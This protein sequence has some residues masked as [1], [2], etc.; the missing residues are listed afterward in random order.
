M[1]F[2]RR[3]DDERDGGQEHEGEQIGLPG[4][5]EHHE[6]GGDGG[7]AEVGHPQ[8]EEVLAPDRTGRRRCSNAIATAT[9]PV[10]RTKNSAGRDISEPTN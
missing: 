6:Q 8:A 3:I 2:E 10:F 4:L 9:R 1:V 5:N 7:A